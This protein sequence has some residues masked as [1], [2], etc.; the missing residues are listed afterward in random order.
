M[1][2]FRTPPSPQSYP[3][4]DGCHHITL[5][6]GEVDE[7]NDFGN[8]QQAIKSGYKFE[9][10]DADGDI[11]E[12]TGNPLAGWTIEA[13]NASNTLV[14]TTTTDADGYYEFTLDPGDYT[15]CEVLQDGWTQSYPNGDGCHHITLSSGEVDE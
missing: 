10:M 7:N 13:Y 3:N 4:G 15:V 9:D 5:S 8:Y 1:L 14:A 11:S 2:I 6:S 12:D